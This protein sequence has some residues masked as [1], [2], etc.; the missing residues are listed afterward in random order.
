MAMGY[1]LLLLTGEGAETGS[2]L[3]PEAV[4]NAISSTGQD[5]LASVGS[6]LGTV[7]P[8]AL[9]VMGLVMGITIGIRLF[10]KLTKSG[11][12]G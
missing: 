11:A 2:N 9:S 10:K 12:N 5:I 1:S 8:V 7:A 4:T 3:V 6:V